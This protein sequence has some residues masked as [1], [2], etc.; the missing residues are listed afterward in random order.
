MEEKNKIRNL[1]VKVNKNYMKNII[2]EKSIFENDNIK[3]K[4]TKM[5]YYYYKFNK[6]QNSIN[7]LF[8]YLYFIIQ[9]LFY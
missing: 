7:K 4:L 2:T 9:I 3:E 5:K 6:I 8:Y 1:D